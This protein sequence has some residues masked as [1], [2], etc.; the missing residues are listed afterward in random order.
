MARHQGRIMSP[1]ERDTYS[2]G[3]LSWSKEYVEHLR[4]AHF[5]LI[6][7]SA[8]LIALSVNTHPYDVR[9]ALTQLQEVL[10]L[11]KSRPPRWARENRSDLDKEYEFGPAQDGAADGGRLLPFEREMNIRIPATQ[12]RGSREPEAFRV[13][14]ASD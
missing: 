8:G 13:S 4:K 9:R 1:K 2:Q 3:R 5:S 6:A 12:D 14:L 10:E 7:I 11:K